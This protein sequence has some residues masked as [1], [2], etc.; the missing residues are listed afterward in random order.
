[1]C[2]NN[3]TTPCEGFYYAIKKRGKREIKTNSLILKYVR[4]IQYSKVKYSKRK[5]K[6]DLNTTSRNDRAL[7]RK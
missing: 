1:M 2:A 5:R 6:I 4:A 7:I 3:T